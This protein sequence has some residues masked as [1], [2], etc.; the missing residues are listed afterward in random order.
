MDRLCSKCQK[1]IPTHRNGRAHFDIGITLPQEIYAQHLLIVLGRDCNEIN[2]KF[3][4]IEFFCRNAGRSQTTDL[5][6]KI[7][8]DFIDELESEITIEIILAQKIY[9]KLKVNDQLGVVQKRFKAEHE[10]YWEDFINNLKEI[11][12]N[13]LFNSDIKR[14]NFALIIEIYT[15][16]SGA[17]SSKLIDKVVGSA[18]LLYILKKLIGY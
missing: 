13:N 11:Y 10:G 4:E 14:A 7:F 8:S 18:A 1:P 5:A 12:L 2:N 9:D 3:S 6:G 16:D 15:S 17:I